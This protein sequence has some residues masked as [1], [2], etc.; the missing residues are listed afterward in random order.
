MSAPGI[1]VIWN[2]CAQGCEQAYEHWYRSEHLAERVGIDGFV[3]GWRYAAVDASPQYFTHYETRS[4]D[5]LFSAPYLDRVNNPTLLTRQIMSGTFTNA[6]RSACVRVARHGDQRGAYA[7][8][9]RF[10]GTI[11][12]TDLRTRVMRLG[13]DEQVLRSELWLASSVQ[14]SAESSTE[15]TLRGPDNTISACV[16]LEAT[17][18]PA[19]KTVTD[20]ARANFTD[21]DNVGSY[22]LMCTLHAADRQSSN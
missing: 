11:D 6:I 15:Q 3:S 1:L 5:V 22:R 21:A 12:E 10:T 2:N 18:E 20:N 19:A 4:V 8:A 17:D 14:S 9:I 13:E 7:T 16:L